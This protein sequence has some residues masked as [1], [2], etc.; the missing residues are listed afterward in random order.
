[1]PEFMTAC[2]IP[3]DAIILE[4]RSTSTRENGIETAKILP[5]LPGAKV[6]LTSDFHMYRASR[7]FSKL[8]VQVLLMPVPD[9]MKRASTWRGRYPAIQE[10]AGETM[11]IC[12]Y[13]WKGW[14]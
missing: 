14:I 4:T 3:R 12:Y 7:V 11:K 2:G 10:L 13:Y 8:G 9:A 6:L 5:R 1:M